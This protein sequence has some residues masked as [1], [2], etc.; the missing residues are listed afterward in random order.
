MRLL[1]GIVFFFFTLQAA[2]QI[3]IAES[4]ID[5]GDVFESRGKVSAFFTLTNPYALDTIHILNIET[6]CGCTAILSQDT[7]IAPNSSIE[8]EV[9]YDPAGR[10]GLFMKSIAIE[11]LTGKSERSTMYLKI[12]GNVISEHSLVRPENMEL[13]EYKVA[14]VFFYPITPFDTSYLDFSYIVSFVN[15]LTYEIDFYQFTTIGF[16]VSV[17]DKKYIPDL[18]YLLNFIRFKLLREFERRGFFTSTVFFDEPVFKFAEIP[19]WSTAKIKVLSSNFNSEISEESTIRVTADEFVENTNLV[20]DYQRFSMPEWDE[21]LQ[22]VNFELLGGKL[23]LNSELVLKGI[24]LTPQGVSQKEREKIAGN[25]EKKVFKSLKKSNGVSKQNVSIELDSIGVHPENKFRFVLWDKGD[26]QDRQKF[27]F[28]VKDD[29][30][31]PPLLPTY[32]QST[33]TR[34]TIDT[35]NADFK[36]FWKNIVLN[37]DAGH[38]I[39]MVIEISVS[40]IPRKA[41][42]DN[43]VIAR[44]RAAEISNFLNE[45]FREE[46]GKEMTFDLKPIVHGPEYT[47]DLKKHVDYAQYEYLNL[48]PTTHSDGAV[49]ELNPSPYLVNFDYYFNGVD[50]ASWLFDKFAKYLA[51]AVE[52]D[53]YVELRLES[54]ISRIPIEKNRVNEFLAWSRA[55]ESEKRLRAYVKTK[56]IDENRIIFTE[57]RYLVQGPEYDGTIPILQFRKFQYLKIV[58]QKYLTQE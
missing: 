48:I 27:R 45:M 3:L 34:T 37:Q 55:N 43:L 21:L 36:R 51:A 18:E 1:S 25:F 24:L 54:S 23:F 5:L 35:T 50:T 6:S 10:L 16:E 33:L 53:G 38:A 47:A 13:L 7:L 30:I 31:V 41:G 17:N 39:H 44:K 32:K 15:D 11:T 8:L 56:L 28:E 20:L 52:Q 46:T 42:D 49:K 12:S 58:P 26:E 19:A 4:S 57:Q 22:E 2:G 9:A 14:P 29:Q 40:S